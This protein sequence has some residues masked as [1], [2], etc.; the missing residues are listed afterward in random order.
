MTKTD[1]LLPEKSL[2][3]ISD[4]IENCLKAGADS[5]DAIVG[6]GTAISASCR[7]GKLENFER[8]ESWELGLRVLIGNRQAIVS[9][10]DPSHDTFHDLISKA[11][12][13]ARAVPEDPFVG[14]ASPEQL[15]ATIP[16]LDEC[17][18]LEPSVESL[19]D[20]ARQAED[21]A[22]AVP[23]ITNSEGAETSWNN[24]WIAL[25]A[26]N[27]FAQIR[28]SSRH[29]LSLSVIAGEG[30][31]M[32]RDYDFVSTVWSEDMPNPSIIGQNTGTRAV[33]RL[34]PRKAETARVPVIFSPRVA[35]TLLHHLSASI[36]GSNVA[37]GT[38]FLKNDLHSKVFSKEVNIFDDPLRLR[39][40][41][42]KPFDAEGLKTEKRAIINEGTL[43]TWLLSLT[44]ARQL[45][46]QSTGHASRNPA[47]S[48]SPSATNFF[49]SEGPLSRDSLISN[50]K[51]GI[52]VTELIGM[53]VNLVTGD[54]SRGASG[55]WIDNGE[56]SY[57]VNEVTIA[58]NLKD[59]YANLVP[60]NDL[61]FLYGFNAPTVCINS[62]TVAGR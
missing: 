40:L 49:M 39:G 5:A 13:M 61:E 11:I 19:I 27:G 33:R 34:N 29:S 2:E 53:G 36:N 32:E 50:I 30:T 37:R 62:M 35:N 24:S 20:R 55:F 1:L 14:L 18:P 28:A 56:I 26:S 15:V 46:L 54:Y 44:S 43:T 3:M 25:A 57:P 7:L 4:L 21:A 42:S 60:A 41:R 9:S 51:S 17:D 58:G 6:G 8:S 22:R 59:M 16:D 38:T 48:P 12:D 52:F 45:G 10:A 23:G 31:S 47:S